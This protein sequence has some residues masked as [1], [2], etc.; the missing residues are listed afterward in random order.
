MGDPALTALGG[1]ALT[2]GSQDVG[3]HLAE[4]SPVCPQHREGDLSLAMKHQNKAVMEAEQ[5]LLT[6]MSSPAFV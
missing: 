5:K 3:G 2:T 6:R 4:A 1:L